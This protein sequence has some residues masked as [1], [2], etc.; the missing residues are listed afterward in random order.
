MYKFS[1]FVAILFF[2][3]SVPAQEF[4][5]EDLA[6]FHIM[7][8]EE[9]EDELRVKWKITRNEEVWDIPAKGIRNSQFQVGTMSQGK[10]VN[11]EKITFFG[12]NILMSLFIKDEG[13]TYKRIK[14]ELLKIGYK[15]VRNKIFWPLFK[16]W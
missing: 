14:K 13:E 8:L 12:E 2:A 15:P 1:F 9:L 3:H 4:A 5:V 10:F 16:N 11:L 7:T 6:R